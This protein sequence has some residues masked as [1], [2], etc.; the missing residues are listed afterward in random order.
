MKKSWFTKVCNWRSEKKVLFSFL[1]ILVLLFLII[2]IGEI[3]IRLVT[4]HDN[5]TPEILKSK[6]ENTNLIY[7]PSLFSRHVFQQKEHF[8][9]YSVKDT[10]RFELEGGFE[11]S[12]KW[13]INQKGYRGS[14]FSVTKP[15]GMIRIIIYGGSFV[16]DIRTKK[17][18]DWPHQ[19]EAMLRTEGYPVEVINAGLPGHMSFDSFG[20]F[21][22]EGHY[23]DPD[24]V[25]ICNKWNDIKYFRS[26]VP[27]LRTFLPYVASADPRYHYNGS[28]DSLLC[29]IS[30]L[31][32]HLRNQ[33]YTLKL[34]EKPKATIPMEEYS[35]EISEI[36]L[37]QYQLHF[38]LFIDAAKN[39][40]ITP[41]LMTQPLLVAR[42]NTER[43]KRLIE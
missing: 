32:A 7:A 41:I 38:Q 34:E 18:M 27:L 42:D 20:R 37:K 1:V 11:D 30:Q 12:V 4:S 8:V 29:N 9:K 40:G 22:T 5:I 10:F 19:L 21:F 39:L 26:N 35:S 2:I 33:Y 23:F 24:Y 16:F 31:Y 14:D 13:H 6:I 17:G 43:Q 28:L 36:A 3:Y 15:E 25:V